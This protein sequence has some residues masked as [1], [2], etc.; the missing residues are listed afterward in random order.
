VVARQTT[1]AHRRSLAA[2][3]TAWCCRVRR[4][5]RA[6]EGATAA[7]GRG[8]VTVRAGWGELGRGPGNCSCHCSTASWAA[9]RRGIPASWTPVSRRI[10]PSWRR[11]PYRLRLR[12]H[13]Y[14]LFLNCIDCWPAPGKKS[15]VIISCQFH[16]L[17]FFILT[18]LRRSLELS[19]SR[20]ATDDPVSRSD[21]RPLSS[22]VAGSWVSDNPWLLC[23]EM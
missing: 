1:G 21:A 20:G 19:A 13:R 14:I 7:A 9:R 3:P 16:V 23:A 4:W 8:P 2:P 5:S 17:L 15:Y 6:S 10:S 12:Y 22:L 11:S 18:S